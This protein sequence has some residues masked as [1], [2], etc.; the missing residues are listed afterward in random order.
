VPTSIGYWLLSNQQA[1]WPRFRAGARYR[2]SFWARQDGLSSPVQVQVASLATASIAVQPTWTEHVIEFTGAPPT[3]GAEPLNWTIASPGTLLLDRITIHEVGDTAPGAFWQPVVDTLRR[4]RPS[5]LRLWALQCNKGFGRSLD[6]GLGPVDEANLEMT[7]TQGGITTDA[8]DLH[9]Q[10][11]LCAQVGTEPWIVMSTMFS[12]QEYR[13]LMEYLAG[14]PDTPYGAKRA[15]RGQVKPWTEV[16]PRI[17]LELGNETWNGMF[18]P[19]GFAGRAKEYGQFA[20]LVFRTCKATPGYDPARFRLILNGWVAGTTRKWGYGPIALEQCPSADAT[21][22][23]YYTGG[24]D[25]VGLIKAD[26]PQW[27]WFNILTYSYR[28]LRPRAEEYATTVRTIAAE[29]QR[30]V[31]VLVYEAGPGYTLPGPGKFDLAEQREG[32]SM[33]QAVNALDIFMTNLA[34]GF[35]DQSFFLFRNGHYWSSHN[36]QWGEHI[37]WK[38]LGLRNTQLTGDRITATPT[39]MPTIDLPEAEAVILNQ[40][41]S[42]QRSAKK[43]P[44]MAGVPLIACHPFKDGGRYAT[45]LYSRRIDAITPVTITLPVEPKPTMRLY[46]LAADPAA[47]N[48]DREEVTV[49]EET[50]NDA[51]QTFTIDLPPASVVVVVNEAR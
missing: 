39:A 40:S 25:A 32:K 18:A 49:Q 46:R 47:H 4:Y 31:E 9:Q 44:P 5:T 48:I 45:M 19:Q 22:L 35:G 33:A 50:R 16:F 17:G 15:A 12:P 27:G 37:A 10:L 3:G 41:N 24:W 8:T 6:A 11:A 51:A 1:D 38:A 26:S 21:D 13:N 14:A 7:E 36:R 30:P 2:L 20:D 34:N 29:R 42:A 23:A 43:F 28:M